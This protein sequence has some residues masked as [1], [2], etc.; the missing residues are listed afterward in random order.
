MVASLIVLLALPVATIGEL[1]S[2]CPC[3]EVDFSQFGIG[4]KPIR[5]IC[6]M[7]EELADADR[8]LKTGKHLAQDALRIWSYNPS[9]QTSLR[10]LVAALNKFSASRTDKAPHHESLPTLASSM[11]ESRL[12]FTRNPQ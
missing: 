11:V 2:L 3:S 1:Q 8:L 12:L 5:P 6:M 10:Q 7:A 4:T 9:M